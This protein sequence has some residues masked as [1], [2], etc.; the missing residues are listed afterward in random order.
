[1][2]G[3]A[4]PAVLLVMVSV[5]HAPAVAAE[6]ACVNLPGSTL[7]LHDVKAPV[8]DERVASVEIL[9][10]VATH[11]GLHSR[12]TMMLTTIDLV[13]LVRIAHRIVPQPD[14]SF[15]DAPSEVSIGLG[16]SRR[17]AYFAPDAAS[18]ECV[19]RQMVAHE[20]AHTR[21][22]NATVDHFLD[23]QR[24]ALARG[25]IALKQMPAANVELAKERWDVGVRATVDKAKR[26]L[27]AELQQANA[28]TDHTASLAALADACGGKIRR[29][30]ETGSL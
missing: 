21:S 13:T 15:C 3:S 4:L 22:F 8:L 23:E 12:H 10:Q 20:E 30:E 19:H 11:G 1:M 2:W 27:L 29:L 7:R 25:M 17:A 16:A 26:Q 14:G 5:L 28:A 18:D 6:M 9:D 24:D